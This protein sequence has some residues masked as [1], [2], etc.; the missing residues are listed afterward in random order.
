MKSLRLLVLANMLILSIPMLA[1]K[2]DIKSIIITYEDYSISSY[3]TSIQEIKY[4]LGSDFYEIEGT[5]LTDKDSI[6]PSTIKVSKIHKFVETLKRRC[7]NDND[8]IF[9]QQEID[10]S[11][12]FINDCKN[13]DMEMVL[14]A[15]GIQKKDIIEML[16]SLLTLGKNNLLEARERLYSLN[17][18]PFF[19]ISFEMGNGAVIKICPI[20]IYQDDNWVVGNTMFIADSIMS[21][22]LNDI[23]ISNLFVQLEKEYFMT[24]LLCVLMH[25]QK[26]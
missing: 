20:S 19:S 12:S 26:E 1:N 23:H 5:N 15:N 6:I 24:Y 11:I 18:H 7:K 22:F 4:K 25:L 17:H 16:P 9:T 8:I 2:N 10:K 14:S 3:A 21:K 13:A